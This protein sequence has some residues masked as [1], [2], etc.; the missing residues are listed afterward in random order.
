V[1]LSSNYMAF[2]YKALADDLDDP[3]NWDSHGPALKDINI[4]LRY[5]FNEPNVEY[6]HFFSGNHLE[7]QV[8]SAATSIS[9]LSWTKRHVTRRL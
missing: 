1:A 8:F 2:T 6:L 5:V 4:L 9:I 3:C 7:L